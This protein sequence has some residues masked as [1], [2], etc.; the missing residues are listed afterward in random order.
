MESCLLEFVSSSFLDLTRSAASKKAIQHKITSNDPSST[1]TMKDENAIAL[2]A[3]S[4]GK[5]G[6][7]CVCT[8]IYYT[9]HKV[10]KWFTFTEW[11]EKSFKRLKVSINRKRRR[12]RRKRWNWWKRGKEK[13]SIQEEFIML[14]RSTCKHT[15]DLYA[16]RS[17]RV[18]KRD[19]KKRG[20]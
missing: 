7:V 2:Y 10:Q 5:Y 4:Y 16:Q 20:E 12:R 9:I 11:N 15:H 8:R 18:K 1:S 14:F 19:R 3:Y 17:G 13:K 6:C